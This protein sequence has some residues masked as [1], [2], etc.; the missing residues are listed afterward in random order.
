LKILLVYPHYPD[1]FWSFRHALKFV[2]KKAS[3]PPLSL[4]TV[5]GMLPE[6]WDKKL[7]DMNATDLK[8]RDIRWAD[9][10]FISAMVVQRASAL[11]VIARC[12]KLEKKIV[13]GG[14]L[15]TTEH[16]LIQGVDHY[17]LD[18]AEITLPPFLDDLSRGQARQTYTSQTR[19]ELTLTPLPEWSLLNMSHYSSMCI[20]YSRGCPFNCEFCDIVALYGHMPRTKSKE[21]V[22]GELEA[23]YQSGW[24][25][26]LFIVDD[27]FIGNKKKLKA[28]VLPAII[29]WMKERKYPF[30]L[31]TEASINLADDEDLMN[32]MVEAGFNQVFIGVETP[33]PESLAECDKSQNEQRDLVG[34]IQTVQ[35][36]GLEVQ[37]GFIVG[38]DNDPPSIFKN[39]IE[40]IQKSGIVTAMVGLLTAPRGS[41]LY[42]RLKDEDR[43]T[44]F[45]DGDN[46]NCSTN[47]TPKMRLET[48]VQGYRN[49]MNTIYAP[50]QYYERLKT[51][52]QE[53]KPKK[54]KGPVRVS[55]RQISALSKTIW[56]LGVVDKGR[57]Y[58]WK[59]FFTTL[60]KKPR[61][62]P[63][64]ISLSVYGFHFRKTAEKY[65]RMPFGARKAENSDA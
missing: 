6:N 50:K 2:S 59:L 54:R 1:T 60:F 47:F 28:E 14:P 51:F 3:F 4:L 27:N 53:Y 37:G 19:P 30:S 15:F 45:S 64:A 62:F 65:F 36:H 21:Q 58:Y 52:L 42:Q 39:Q 48:L 63:L 16:D 38:F 29:A 40:F 32:M 24:R 49:V 11:G 46:T 25:G 18:E 26:G 57:K 35:Q 22:A 8:D 17:V 5:A 23:L 7:V 10:V 9:Y 44:G 33:N 55:I 43:L 56:L 31:S 61:V 13:A 20:Q 12:N 41:R 34:A